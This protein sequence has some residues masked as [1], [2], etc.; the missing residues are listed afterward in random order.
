MLCLLLQSVQNR[1]ETMR[2]FFF[3]TCSEL[4]GQAGNFHV[5][6]LRELV[7]ECGQEFRVYFNDKGLNLCNNLL[8]MLFLNASHLDD[9]FAPHIDLLELLA[10]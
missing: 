10:G 6:G 1:V 2:S 3:S 5:L 9:V 4:E 7:F 8:Q